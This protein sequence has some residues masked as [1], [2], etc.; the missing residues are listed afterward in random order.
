MTD[1]AGEEEVARQAEDERRQSAG[2]PHAGALEQPGG[3]EDDQR[4]P[5]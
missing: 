2:E 3:D 1:D 5:W 4:L